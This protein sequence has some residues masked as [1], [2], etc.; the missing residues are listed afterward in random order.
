MTITTN[1]STLPEPRAASPDHC[2][3]DVD[4]IRLGVVGVLSTLAYFV[5]F[6]GLREL[7]GPQVANVAALVITAVA[8]TA[9]NRR[10]TFGA[11][12]RDSLLRHQAGGLIAFGVG[13]LLTSGSLWLL[14]QTLA[15]PSQG[16]RSRSWWSPMR[17][18]P[19]SASWLCDS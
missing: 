19:S 8:N 14:H 10:L 5:I 17:S 7:T 2:S 15:S 11:T 4:V 9:T 6:L 12:G 3:S 1:R 13:L 16:S 18:P